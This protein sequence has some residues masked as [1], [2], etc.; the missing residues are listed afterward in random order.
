MKLHEQVCYQKQVINT[1]EE[2]IKSILRYLHSD[3]F[4]GVENNQ[5]NPSDIVSDLLNIRAE[6]QAI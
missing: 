4:H 1:Y 5:V 3:K 2:G 6:V